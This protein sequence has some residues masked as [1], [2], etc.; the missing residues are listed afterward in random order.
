MS[1]CLEFDE[2]ANV[3]PVWF[4]PITDLLSD[5]EPLKAMTAAK[6]AFVKAVKAKNAQDKCW[7]LLAL[8]KVHL[9]KMELN[10]ANEVAEK[11]LAELAQTPDDMLN[12]AIMLTIAKANGDLY[13]FQDALEFADEAMSR[14]Q[15]AGS[16]V[17][18]AAALNAIARIN[19]K[20]ER[21]QDALK[22]GKQALAMFRDCSERNGEAEALH[23]MARANLSLKK[24]EEALRV[25]NQLV[26]LFEG[27]D[28]KR[29]GAALFFI[30]DIRAAME[31]YEEAMDIARRAVEM[32]EMQDKKG[33]AAATRRLAQACFAKGEDTDG[34]MYVMEALELYREVGCVKCE[35]EMLND[36][37]SAHFRTGT[38]KEG[39]GIAEEGARLA[40]ESGLRKQYAD[41]LQSQARSMLDLDTVLGNAAEHQLNWKARLAA[42]DALNTY[43]DIG[44]LRGQMKSQNTLALAFMS[45]GNALEGRAKA[46]AAMEISKI[47]NDKGSEGA[48]LLLVAQSR[49]HDNREEA[50]RLASQAQRL[51]KEGGDQVVIREAQDVVDVLRDDG[52][53]EKKKKDK[54]PQQAQSSKIDLTLDYDFGKTRA[55]YF[56]GFISRSTR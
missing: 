20:R 25:G 48:N 51:I 53:Q 29:H 50:S 4:K 36:V 26:G 40:R 47:M 55:A 42:K 33:Q 52:K 6:E 49:F 27:Q 54:A 3:G 12:G 14:F 31:E 5:D 21:R 56:H 38:H 28:L 1:S 32:F 22:V 11:A 19:L 39:Q 10:D 23:I 24:F 41:M 37:A 13:R 8:A 7:A 16:K 43:Q 35:V 34:W 15:A 30:A 17:G 44:D 18:E 45:Y 9:N 46:K 2:V